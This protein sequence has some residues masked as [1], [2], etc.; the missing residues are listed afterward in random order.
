MRPRRA[1]MAGI[2]IALPVL[3][4]LHRQM[5]SCRPP[6][7]ACKLRSFGGACMNSPNQT[8][9]LRVGLR[10]IP[11]SS[12]ALMRAQPGVQRGHGSKTAMAVDLLLHLPLCHLVWA[13]RRRPGSASRRRRVRRRARSRARS[14]T[15][16]A[17]RRTRAG[18][19]W[20]SR[21]LPGGVGRVSRARAI[22]SPGPPA[23][24]LT[25]GS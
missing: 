10:P 17:R 24:T 12:R 4:V 19:T 22:R 8:L 14:A 2:R 15:P 3:P 5:A 21:L 1:V 7:L 23:P 6:R 11:A 9:D 25:A 13:A 20:R 16:T 18:S